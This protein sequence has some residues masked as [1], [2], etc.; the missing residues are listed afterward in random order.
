VVFPSHPTGGSRLTTSYRETP[1]LAI[2]PLM[3]ISP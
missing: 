2:K 3:V 1:D